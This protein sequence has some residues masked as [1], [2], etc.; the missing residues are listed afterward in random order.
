MLDQPIHEPASGDT[1]G[2]I[3]DRDQLERGFRRLSTE[4]RAV[5]VLHHY[6]DLPRAEIARILDIP[7]GTVHSRLRHAMR[8]LRAA[9]EADARPGRPQRVARE[10]T[11]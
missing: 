8:T 6:A 9:L 2:P 1:L 3:I 4:Q 11:R 10:A 7:M 5:V